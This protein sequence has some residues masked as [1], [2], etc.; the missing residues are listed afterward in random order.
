MKKVVLVSLSMAL[1]LF[2]VGCLTS[3]ID[4]IALPLYVEINGVKWAT[5]NLAA[6]GIFAE[7]AESAGMFY[8]WGRRVG[9]S[10]TN[11]LVASNGSTLWSSFHSEGTEWR[12]GNNP[13][14]AGWRLPTSAEQHSLIEAGSVW[15]T[16]NRVNGRL[17]GTPPHQIFL[18]AA[19][20]RMSF[21]GT[22]REVSRRGVY[23]SSTSQSSTIAT[24]VLLGVID[25]ATYQAVGDVALGHSVRCVKE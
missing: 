16:K 20:F 4:D 5:K 19:G 17:F 12:V 9:W 10:N 7:R 25:D 3:D 1:C 23:W 18:P 13:C 6:P 15:T 2:F 22:L 8:Q 21:D 11:P 24:P 14:P